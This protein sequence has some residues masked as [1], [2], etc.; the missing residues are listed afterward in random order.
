M[1]SLRDISVG[2]KMLIALTLSAGIALLV[3]LVVVSASSLYRLKHQTQQQL[4]AL[5]DVTGQ[6]SQAALVFGDAQSARD[7]LSNL[8]SNALVATAA[9]YDDAGRLFASQPLL[10]G[11][12]EF[13]S[14]L[15]TTPEEN[16]LTVWHLISGRTNTVRTITLDGKSIGTVMLV[17]DL[18][19][20]WR[21]WLTEV[22]MML[23][24]AAAAFASAIL[25]GVYMRRLIVGPL[26]ELSRTVEAVASDQDYSM[27]VTSQSRDEIG[28]LMNRF[29]EMLSQI[30]SRDNEIRKLAYFD[31]LT[32]LPNRRLL[33]DRLQ[34]ALSACLRS[35]RQ[36]ALLFIDLD[37]FKTINDTLGH[38]KGDMLLEQVAQRLVTC[39]REGDTV[40]RLGGDEFVVMLEDLS[41]SPKEAATQAETVAT[42]ILT[43]L[44]QPYLID[45]HDYRNTPS[46]GA[47]LFGDNKNSLDELLKRAD[48]A[49]Y[50]AKAA[51]RN[52]LRFFDPEMQA[53][54]TT[55]AALDNDLREALQGNQFLLHYQPQVDDMRRL[56]GVEALLRWQHPRRGLVSPADFVPL[57][58]ETG[59][60]LPLGQ[61]VLESACAQL[62]NWSGLPE[63]SHLSLAV[64]VS[65]HQFRQS[66]FVERVS[67]VLKASGASPQKLKLELT[68]SLLLDDVEDTVAKMNALKVMGVSFSLDDFGTGYSSLA[69]LKRLPLDQLKIDQSFVRD[70][71]TDPN[72]AV[73][74][75]T[76]VALAQ[77]MGLAVI[78][79]GVETGAQLEFLAAN[80]C[81][82]YQ[83]YYFSRP[84]SLADFEKLAQRGLLTANAGNPVSPTIPG[85]VLPILR[86]SMH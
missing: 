14:L 32:R 67:T 41:Q 72:D 63:M 29:N 74:A 65:A 38:D 62:A 34:H 7:T 71:L 58:E 57:A 59:L 13:P 6:N 73:I 26:T 66:D 19:P 20:S 48:M 61:W 3:M 1:T 35:K 31:P 52:T 85:K 51:G 82:V 25:L 54:V 40:A 47:T 69:Y 81:K 44:N 36:G 27:R 9:I 80:G 8:R 43:A 30:E 49:M 21:S 84:L 60:I 39:V 11:E 70:I 46:I 2:R 4:T 83:G 12:P 16:S 75:C 17:A 33:L 53:A 18:G 37:N 24:A 45:A 42:K 64:N 55:R 78:A 68:E 5:A 86:P 56:L 10:L 79:E 50:Q 28:Q 22:G 15:G 76:V 77:S 23:M